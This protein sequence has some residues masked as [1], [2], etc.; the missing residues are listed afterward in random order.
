MPRCELLETRHGERNLTGHNGQNKKAQ[1]GLKYYQC[2]P[3]SRGREEGLLSMS[4]T[5]GL[6][7]KAGS[8][9]ATP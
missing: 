5:N 7:A 8:L 6:C 3:I 1:A 4:R 2:L 9:G